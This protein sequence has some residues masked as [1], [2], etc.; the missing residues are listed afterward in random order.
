M[1]DHQTRPL[2]SGLHHVSAIASDAQHTVDFYVGVL[3]LRLV[4]QTVNGNDREQLHLFFGDENGAPGSVITHFIWPE[5]NPAQHGVG[6]VAVTS[7]AIGPESMGYWLERLVQ[8]GIAFEGPTPRQIGDS[9]TEYV[10]AFR[11]PDGLMLELVSPGGRSTRFVPS[12]DPAAHA[13][14]GLHSVTLWVKRLDTIAPLLTGTLGFRAAGATGSTHRFIVG[15]GMPGQIVDVREV[16]GFVDARTG[17]GGV[18]HV[19]WTVSD[20]DF[21]ELSMR[22]N[23]NDVDLSGTVDRHY[24]TSRYVRDEDGILHEFATPGPGFTSD[25]ALEHLGETLM[26]P[27][28]WEVFRTYLAASLPSFTLPRASS[29]FDWFASVPED[30]AMAYE[31]YEYVYEPGDDTGRVLLTLHGTGG[32]ERSLLPLAAAIAPGAPVLSPRGKVLEGGSARRFF[33]RFAEV[34]LDQDDLRFRTAEMN[35]FARDALATHELAGDRLYALGFSNGAN[36]AASMLLRG[37]S[38]LAGAI[39]LSPMLPF[40]PESLP[41]LAGVDIF[42]GAG[43]LDGMIPFAQAES[44]ADVLRRS[45]A[46]V[47]LFAFDG[48]HTVT[49]AELEA[50]RTWFAER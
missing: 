28:E 21:S 8:L 6:E 42:I 5:G 48:G 34:Q 10:L 12:A 19:A 37:D 26:L 32:D 46:D 7:F 45:G 23:G 1:D 13:I 41:D 24:F 4:K 20:D 18:D 3:G 2:V 39:L 44:L 16:G 31:P 43:R 25:E 30:A 35:A 15:D 38:P 9:P 22:L 33:R 36:L 29:E 14:R 50:A 17:V 40:V 27:A 49:S 11:D 47:T